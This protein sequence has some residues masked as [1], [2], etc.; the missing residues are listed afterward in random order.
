[1][2]KIIFFTA[3][4]ILLLSIISY[5]LYNSYGWVIGLTAFTVIL[6]LFYIIELLQLQ[7]EKQ[8]NIANF[9]DYQFGDGYIDENNKF[10]K[11]SEPIEDLTKEPYE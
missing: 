4:K 9:L 11:K 10:H 8:Q 5:S 1:M 2:T 3:L 6:S 7:I